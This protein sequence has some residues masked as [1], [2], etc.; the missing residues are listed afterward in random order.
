MDVKMASLA[1]VLVAGC[2]SSMDWSKPGSN[3][4]A[5]NADLKAC[6][7]AAESYP[8]LPRIQTAPASATGSTSTGTDVDA[9][10]QLQRAQRVETCMRERGYQ[11]V[12]K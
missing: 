9:D 12:R 3:E 4:Q 11:L 10:V 8:A 2:A 1:L 6:R 7:L 5:V